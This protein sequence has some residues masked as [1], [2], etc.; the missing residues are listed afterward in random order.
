MDKPSKKKI[1]LSIAIAIMLGGIIGFIASSEEKIDYK[2]LDKDGSKSEEVTFAMES[3]HTYTMAFFAFD[4]EMGYE[5]ADLDV[6]VT[7]LVNGEVIE[8]KTIQRSESDESDGVKRAEDGFE[9]TYETIS[10]KDMV[11]RIEMI[12]GDTWEIEIYE[13]L[14][15]EDNM[16]PVFF[17]TLGIGG[18]V[19]LLKVRN[20]EE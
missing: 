11:I 1:L 7:V 18:L 6:K 20:L 17:I 8:E 12:E 4:E 16:M 14:P 10:N 9:V 15:S 19:M 2:V 5:W 13:D 3:G